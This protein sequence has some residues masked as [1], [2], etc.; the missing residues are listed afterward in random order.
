MPAQAKADTEAG[1]IAFVKH[2][3]DVFNYASNTGDVAELQRL[4][5]PKCEGCNNYIELYKNTYAAGGYFKDSDW[6][7]SSPELEQQDKDLV[8]FA[9][10]TAPAGKFK[11]GASDPEKLGD[12]ENDDLTFVPNHISGTWILEEFGREKAAS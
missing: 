5:D 8:V 12:P 2:Y 7:L 11:K 10:A 1:A 6:V 9:H 3:I 4:S